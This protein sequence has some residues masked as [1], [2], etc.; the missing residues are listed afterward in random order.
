MLARMLRFA[1]CVLTTSGFSQLQPH[2]CVFNVELSETETLASSVSVRVLFIIFRA[3]ANRC[4][5]SPGSR[6]GAALT[7]FLPLQIEL[8]LVIP[9]GET[10]HVSRR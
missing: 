1:G 8:A 2:V 4:L 10:R 9:T 6:P 5:D 7:A 3:T